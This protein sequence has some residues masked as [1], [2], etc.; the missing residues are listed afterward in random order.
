MQSIA[1]HHD[2][3]KFTFQVRVFR[4]C[5][6]GS[7]I[8]TSIVSTQSIALHHIAFEIAFSWMG[9]LTANIGNEPPGIRTDVPTSH[10]TGLSPRRRISGRWPGLSSGR[11]VGPA[12]VRRAGSPA[13]GRARRPDPRASGRAH[14]RR[15]ACPG[16]PSCGLPGRRF[17]G[18]AARRHRW[19]G[20]P[21]HVGETPPWLPGCREPVAEAPSRFR[22]KPVLRRP[23]SRL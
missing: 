9:C 4:G 18:L 8:L 22:L 14:A 6:S 15:M 13:Y 1:P 11:P 3:K 10:G 16:R 17:A 7:D 20:R 21:T 12:G 2:A 23:E 19:S 5:A